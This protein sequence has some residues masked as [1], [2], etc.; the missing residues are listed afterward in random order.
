MRD[1][2]VERVRQDSDT[3]STTF[4]EYLA[5][6]QGNG[7]RIVAAPINLGE[8]GGYRIVQIGAFF[9]LTQDEYLSAMGGNKP[10]CAE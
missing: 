4:A 5:N 9:L 2:L 1:A 6:G 3:T 8:P 10:F 7:R